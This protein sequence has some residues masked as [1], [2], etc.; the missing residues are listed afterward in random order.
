MATPPHE[1]ELLSETI[2]QAAR[3]RFLSARADAAKRWSQ[4]GL[5]LGYGVGALVF[6]IAT[7]ATMDAVP[8]W[9]IL[10]SLFA[11]LAATSVTIAVVYPRLPQPGVPCP[12]CARR[13]PLAMTQMSPVTP[14]K[15]LDRCPHCGIAL[16]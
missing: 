5:W 11:A 4:R 7:V 13:I 8:D 14:I 12:Q 15:W 3:E 9:S 16:A 6:V 1:S 2:P 10:I